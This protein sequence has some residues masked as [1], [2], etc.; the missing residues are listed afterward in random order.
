MAYTE[1][2]VKCKTPLTRRMERS[3]RVG[4]KRPI[5]VHN[6]SFRLPRAPGAMEDRK[7]ELQRLAWTSWPAS[8]NS[9]NISK[10]HG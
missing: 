10:T 2:L 1:A 8:R 6:G 5:R 7:E 3:Y 9:M 4:C